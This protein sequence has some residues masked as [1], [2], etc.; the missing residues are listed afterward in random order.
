M[1]FFNLFFSF[2]NRVIVIDKVIGDF[3]SLGEAVHRLKGSAGSY[4]F[5]DLQEAAVRLEEAARAESAAAVETAVE[6]VGD[7]V[8]ASRGAFESLANDDQP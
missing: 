3:E 6:A 4:G 5:H 8:T 2:F 1:Q 7:A